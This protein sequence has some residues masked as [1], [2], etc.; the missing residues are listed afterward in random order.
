MN[1][2]KYTVSLTEDQVLLV[3]KLVCDEWYKISNKI[4]VCEGGE[5]KENLRKKRDGL[6]ELNDSIMD[7]VLEIMYKYNID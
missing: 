7:A 1:E 4:L 2:E 5:Q 3:N 6:M